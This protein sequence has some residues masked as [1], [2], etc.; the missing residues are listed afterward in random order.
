M[1]GIH[2]LL[3]W[4]SHHEYMM[5]LVILVVSLAAT[6]IFVGNL[7]AIVYAFGQ[8]VWWGIG[9]LL[10]PLFSIVYCARNWERA[11]YPG[12]MIYAGLAALGLTYIALLI[13]MAVDPV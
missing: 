7:F 12:K 5:M 8:S 13:M 11:A 4:L 1:L 6:L 10:I 9:V 3:T 2:G